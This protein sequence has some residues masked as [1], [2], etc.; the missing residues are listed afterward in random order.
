MMEALHAFHFL[1]PWWLLALLGL[2]LAL[3]WLSRGDAGERALSRLVD[4]ALL[5]HL[6]AGQPVGRRAAGWLLGLGWLLAALAFAGP[7]WSRR[8]QPLFGERA[9]QVVAFSLS[10]RMLARDVAPSRLDR[11]KYKIRDLLASNRDGQNALVAYAGEAFVVAPL[12]SDAASLDELLDALAPD[13]MPTDGDN[14]TQAIEQGMKLIAQAKAGGGSVVLVTDRVDPGAE[15]AA[16]RALAQGVHVS[17][18]GIGTRAGGPVPLDGGGFLHDAQGNLE[19]AK[20]DDAA[21]AAVASAGGGRYVAATDDPADIRAL[22]AAL[23]HASAGVAG[24]Q[25]S[26]QWL[27]RG[28]W[29]LLPLLAIVA[30]GFRRGWLLV[31]PLVC[32]IGMPGAAHADGW[33]DLWLRPDQQA[34]RALKH[35]DAAAARKLAQDPALRAAA[36]YR[37]GDYAAAER[38]LSGL[39]GSDAEYNLGNALAK[40]GQYQEAIAA[41]DRALKADPHNADAQANR[42]VVEDWLRR[43]PPPSKGDNGAQDDKDQGKNGQPSKGQQGASSKPSGQ[44]KPSDKGGQNAQGQQGASSGQQSQSGQSQDQT[45]GEGQAK[46]QT[47]EQRA[48]EQ[49]RAE[50]ARQA[51]QRQMDQ[52]LGKGQRAKGKPDQPHQLGLPEEGD[53]SS[54]LPADV[55]QA[56]QRVPDDPGA[57]LRRKFELEYRQRH[58]AA[59]E[60]DSP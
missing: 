24:D 2:P 9:A 14:A 16:R 5:P 47:P 15:A 27:D 53:P 57:L 34:S 22:H 3:W 31:L 37:S 38:Q 50:A 39:T 33:R 35:G 32:L 36:D 19:L 52:A 55:R 49:A 11:A 41:Y 13:T 18:L 54:R 4:P 30:L 60:D 40:Q 8:P 23:P 25:R 58:G 43:Q 21:L 1:R 48:A 6:L 45:G 42:K 28:P 44:G 20:R 10:P 59:T 12:T 26:E 56:L 7:T 29:L 17:V 46:P 51:L